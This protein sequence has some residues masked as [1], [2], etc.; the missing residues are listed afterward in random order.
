MEEFVE[1]ALKVVQ[2]REEW[3]TYIKDFNYPYGFLYTES[4]LLLQIKN[5]IDAENPIHSGASLAMCLQE[6]KKLLN[7]S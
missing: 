5:A 4:E 3:I 1:R 7:N 2:S 6:C